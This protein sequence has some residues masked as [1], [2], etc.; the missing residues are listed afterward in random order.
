MLEH[1]R[2]LAD[3]IWRHEQIKA[4]NT[5][6]WVRTRNYFRVNQSTTGSGSSNGAVSYSG[7]ETEIYINIMAA[8]QSLQKVSALVKQWL[9]RNIINTLDCTRL[10]RLVITASYFVQ[11]AWDVSMSHLTEVNSGTSAWWS[12][13]EKESNSKTDRV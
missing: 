3:S 10:R 7:I 1:K 5:E 8:K 11:L 9:F 12:E 13:I 4:C 6:L 2:K